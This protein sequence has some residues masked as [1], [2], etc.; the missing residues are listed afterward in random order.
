MLSVFLPS[1]GNVLSGVLKAGISLLNTL[2]KSLTTLGN[3]LGLFETNNPENLGVKRIQ[4]EEIGIEPENYDTYDEYL[5]VID[6]FEIDEEKAADIPLEDKLAKAA[7]H[8]LEALDNKYP[9]AEVTN[10][11]KGVTLHEEFY[12]D[13]RFA[14]L[15]DLVDHDP[16]QMLKIGKLL[17]GELGEDERNDTIDLLVSAE[18]TKNPELST[19]E[20]VEKVRHEL[21]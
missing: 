16:D 3:A 9:G 15:A 17:C 14:V 13:E 2:S 5:S 8:T 12:N 21:A 4:A 1:L 18:Q 10:L 20:I 11:A 7:Q 6:S 19:E